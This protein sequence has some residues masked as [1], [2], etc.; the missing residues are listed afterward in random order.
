MD[1]IKSIVADRLQKA[2]DNKQ[3]TQTMLEEKS[4]VAKSTI[5]KAINKGELSVKMAKK[6]SKALNV[7]LDY[8]YGNDDVEN[9]SQYVL[10]T[11]MKH[12]SA[13]N[14]KSVWDG[15]SKFTTST[16]IC[17]PRCTRPLAVA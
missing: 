11:M 16:P 7:S 5:S 10:D 1:N 2:L 8:L 3:F 6:I 13:Y 15:D 14:R 9:L 4:Q 17:W 12:I